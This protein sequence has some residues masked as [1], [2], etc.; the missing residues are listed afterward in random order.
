MQQTNANMPPPGI[1]PTPY[2]PGYSGTPPTMKQT[3]PGGYDMMNGNPGMPTGPNY[4]PAVYPAPPSSSGWS[5]TNTGSG[6]PLTRT[7][8]PQD[9]QSYYNYAPPPSDPAFMPNH[10]AG[11]NQP[12]PWNPAPAAAAGA[13]VAGATAMYSNTPSPPPPSTT[14]GATSAHSGTTSGY[15]PWSIPHTASPGPSISGI[16]SGSSSPAPPPHGMPG[17]MVFPTAVEEKA[18]YSG[19]QP[20]GTG[21]SFRGKEEEAKSRTSAP[22]PAP[23]AYEP[24][25]GRR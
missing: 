17:G 13:G 15:A 3:A 8:N 20:P 9:R 24:F 23:P 10:N 22:T 11:G 12:M 6:A 21:G 1:M 18:H 4:T 25:T 14:P 5:G 7:S 2:N 19:Y 16:A